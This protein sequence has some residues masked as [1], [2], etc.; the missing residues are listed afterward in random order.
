[1]ISI[2]YPRP[3]SFTQGNYFKS[4]FLFNLSIYI[5]LFPIIKWRKTTA[6]YEYPFFNAVHPLARARRR[7]IVFYSFPILV[8]GKRHVSSFP[9]ATSISRRLGR[10]EGILVPVRITAT[11]ALQACIDADVF[12]QTANTACLLGIL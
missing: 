3:L 11:E 12:K 6:F 4:S 1:L 7:A 8:G 5:L 9:T 10:Y 2:P